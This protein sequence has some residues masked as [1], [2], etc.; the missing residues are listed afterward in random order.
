MVVM[1]AIFSALVSSDALE[2]SVQDNRYVKEDREKPPH[3]FIFK[4]HR[5]P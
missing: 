3:C 2:D 5:Y 4:K 1:V